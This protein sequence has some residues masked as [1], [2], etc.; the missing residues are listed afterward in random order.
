L[1]IFIDGKNGKNSRYDNTWYTTGTQGK[2]GSR[3]PFLFP[4]REMFPNKS[5][6]LTPQYPRTPVDS[7]A[8][9][10]CPRLDEGL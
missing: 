8:P 10:R 7:F 1:L 2:G 9:G 6:Q 3:R 5:D 4:W